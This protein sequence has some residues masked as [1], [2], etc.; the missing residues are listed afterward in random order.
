MFKIEV[1]F[2]MIFNLIVLYFFACLSSVLAHENLGLM[3]A[4]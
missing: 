2:K 1:S 3:W 4:K